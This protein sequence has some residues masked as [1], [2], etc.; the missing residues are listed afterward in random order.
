MSAVF[1]PKIVFQILLS[2]D[3]YSNY[4]FGLIYLV[5]PLVVDRLVLIIQSIYR[6]SLTLIN[7]SIDL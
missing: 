1:V 2:A 7:S 5:D 4:Y 6:G 3:R